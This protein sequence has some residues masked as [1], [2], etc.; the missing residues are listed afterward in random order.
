M[1]VHHKKPKGNIFTDDSEHWLA[2]RRK[3]FAVAGDGEYAVLRS[4]DLSRL[5]LH[6]FVVQWLVFDNCD[7]DG[8]SF[9]DTDFT[10]QAAFLDCSLRGSDFTNSFGGDDLFYKCDL[11]RAVFDTSQHWASVDLDGRKVPSYFVNC[12][13][14]DELRDFLKWDGNIVTERVSLGVQQ[15]L[16]EAAEAPRIML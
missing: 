8:A 10:F 16:D 4:L 12:A 6:D 14:G 3:R 1:D 15:R 5:D 11:K 2:F 9:R 7:L 13:M